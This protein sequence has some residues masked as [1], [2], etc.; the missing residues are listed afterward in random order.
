MTKK[1]IL[2]TDPGIDDAMAILFAEA[3]PDIELMGITTVYGN[4]TID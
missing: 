2:D 1:I 3:H 4:A